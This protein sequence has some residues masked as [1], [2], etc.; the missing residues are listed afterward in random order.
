MEEE[1][2]PKQASAVNATDCFDSENFNSPGNTDLCH[3]CASCEYSVDSQGL[4]NGD[5]KCANDP[6]NADQE[7]FIKVAFH[8][9]FQVL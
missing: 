9:Y 1:Y 7:Y 6:D 4:L 8:T 5:D 3:R 2:N